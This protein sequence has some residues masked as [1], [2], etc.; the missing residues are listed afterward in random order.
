MEV[1]NFEITAANSSFQAAC[2]VPAVRTLSMI[3]ERDSFR[4]VRF[5]SRRPMM[6]RSAAKT[7]ACTKR[8]GLSSIAKIIAAGTTSMDRRVCGGVPLAAD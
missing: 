7:K 1:I 8:W 4:K 3:K 5:V 2:T 6:L